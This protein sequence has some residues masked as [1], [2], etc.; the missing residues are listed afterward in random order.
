MAGTF[1]PA[2]KVHIYPS[3]L[4]QL[5]EREFLC[6]MAETIKH[7]C[8]GDSGLFSLLSSRQDEIMKREPAVLEEML[9]C[10]ITV[11]ADVVREDLRETGRKGPSS[12]WGIQFAHALESVYNLSEQKHGEAVAWGVVKAM[13]PGGKAGCDRSRLCPGG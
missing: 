10:S 9:H 3:I 5:P 12:T 6:G 11:K 13:H 2:G 8:L 7:A 4:K 1:Y